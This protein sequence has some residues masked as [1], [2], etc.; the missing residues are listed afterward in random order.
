MTLPTV[1]IALVGCGASKLARRAPAKDLYTSSL[2]RLSRAFAEQGEHWRIVSAKFGLLD[3]E[4]IIEPYE[5][6]LGPKDVDHWG[7][8]VANAIVSTFCFEDNLPIA[9]AEVVFL[10]GKTYASAIRAALFGRPSITSL[11]SP[12]DHMGLGKRMQWLKANTRISLPS[13]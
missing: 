13:S 10:C 9:R 5:Q 6:K 3:P 7:K 12:L 8:V 4:E 1:R 2:F 11:E